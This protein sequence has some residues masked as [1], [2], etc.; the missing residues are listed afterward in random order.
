MEA[1]VS[2]LVDDATVQVAAP[3]AIR[4]KAFFR[5]HEVEFGF[6]EELHG[7]DLVLVGG[8]TI[9][10]S[11]VRNGRFKCLLGEAIDLQVVPVGVDQVHR[12]FAIYEELSPVNSKLQA[13]LPTA[14][15][16][17]AILTRGHGERMVIAVLAC[18]LRG[19]FILLHQDEVLPGIHLQQ[20]MWRRLC[21]KTSST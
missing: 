3:A 21:S 2:R 4:Q 15:Q 16:Q 20:R 5:S 12:I 7:P 18:G 13:L 19:Y 6:L 9:N 17:G 1:P 8:P 11:Q 14:V 10:H